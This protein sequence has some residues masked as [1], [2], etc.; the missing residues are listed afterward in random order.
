MSEEQPFFISVGVPC[1]CGAPLVDLGIA[2]NGE[3]PI[4]R[5]QCPV[6]GHVFHSTALPEKMASTTL[7]ELRDDVLEGL[8]RY[9]GSMTV[10]EAHQCS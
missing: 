6:S 4:W 7:T 10:E 9:M 1:P 8:K 3:R 5:F 2:V